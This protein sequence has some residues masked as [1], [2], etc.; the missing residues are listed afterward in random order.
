MNTI[1]IPIKLIFIILLSMLFDVNKIF[2]IILPNMLILSA[3]IRCMILHCHK[4]YELTLI[5]ILPVNF[6]IQVL[7][8]LCVRRINSPRDLSH[9]FRILIC[10]AVIRDGLIH[11]NLF[12]GLLT[13]IERQVKWVNHRFIIKII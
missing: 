1:H 3:P 5:V 10:A 7:I 8:S 9:I 11:A 4:L 13:I 2:F 12:I 6:C